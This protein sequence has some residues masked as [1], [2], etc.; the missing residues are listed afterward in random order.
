[1]KE[2]FEVAPPPEA[3]FYERPVASKTSKM[4]IYYLTKDGT[5]RKVIVNTIFDVR[6]WHKPA[7][8]VRIEGFIRKN[9]LQHRCVVTFH[10]GPTKKQVG[11]ITI[12]QEE[13]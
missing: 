9:K 2:Y 4:K 12:Y 6:D 5:R 8:L 7:H 10:T 11:S 3:D 13:I 1:M